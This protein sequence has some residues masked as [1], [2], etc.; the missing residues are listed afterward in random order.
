MACGGASFALKG[1]WVRRKICFRRP[2]AMQPAG[3]A[4]L[5]AFCSIS[6]AM[7]RTAKKLRSGIEF[8]LGIDNLRVAPDDMAVSRIQ[9][10][11]GYPF[12]VTL[13]VT[14]HLLGKTR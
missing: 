2:S 9:G 11:P 12:G 8:N 13:G 6:A 3:L 1:G 10:S 5:S 14:F 7:R 4:L